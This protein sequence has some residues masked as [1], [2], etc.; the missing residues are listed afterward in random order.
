LLN[1]GTLTAGVYYVRVRSAIPSG[2][3]V[4]SG[5][6][7]RV[8]LPSGG[9]LIIMAIDGLTGLAVPNALV[10]IDDLTS[11]DF[12]GN[13]TVSK[14][15]TGACK[16][17]VQVPDGYFS[18]QDSATPGQ[19]GNSAN[20]TYG[21]PRI[22]P[23]GCK[24]TGFQFMPYVR[25]NART[26][27]ATIGSFISDAKVS[28]TAMSGNLSGIVYTQYPN[29][30]VYGVPWQTQAD[31]GFPTNVLLPP[32]SWNLT[33]EKSGY[34]NF[35]SS[36]TMTLSLTE[37]NMGTFYLHPADQNGNSL[38]D[39]WEA[40]YFAP[41]SNVSAQEDGDVDGLN[42]WQEYM[43]G[44][45]PTN[46]TS[47]FGCTTAPTASA[48]ALT[49]VWPVVPGRAYQVQRVNALQTNAWQSVSSVTTAGVG[50][51]SMQWTDANALVSTQYFYRLRILSP[52]L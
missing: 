4:D 27:D 26:L 7:L 19:V 25:V 6:R 3:G 34:S 24:F 29:W 41:G 51:T 12:N 48:N 33:I 18:V 31:G 40:A 52:A 23:L 21:N 22:V 9:Q 2:W 28:F 11:L 5:Y 30:A 16:V 42:N 32:I 44:T 17:E 36:G 13:L 39:A 10:T 1:S 47:W 38:P 50:Q 46:H 8:Y 49:F 37:T 45:D 35:I 14:E 43:A 20:Q 15:M